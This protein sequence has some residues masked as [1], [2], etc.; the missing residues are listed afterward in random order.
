MNQRTLDMTRGKPISLIT[1]FAL[2]LMLGN[3]FQ[4]FY[5]VVDTA[6]VGKALGVGV[7]AAMGS[8]DWLGWMMVS[9]I[10]GLTQGFG[11]LMAQCFGARDEAGLRKTAGA[12][13]VLSALSAVVLLIAGQLAA[14]PVLRLLQTPE[15]IMHHGVQYLRYIFA[16]VPISMAYNLLACTLRSLGDGKTPLHA[17]MVA[18][19]VNVALDLL[20]VLAFR[21]GI[22]GAA[23][24]TLIAQACSVAF[25][26]V[27]IRRLPVL[28]LQKSDLHL[29]GRRAWRL[30]RLGFPVA[31]Q[32]AIISVGGMIVQTVVNGFGVAFIAGFTATNK[33]Y[34]VLEIAATSY[35]YAMTTYAGQNLGAGNIQRIRQGTRAASWVC[36]VI[37]G[38]IA[39]IM[40]AFGRTVVGMFI[41]GTPEETK[42]AI[43][44][45][46]KYLTIMAACLPSLYLLYVFRSTI[47]GVG[48][49]VLPMT[50]GIAEFVMRVC[51]ALV[52]PLLVGEIGL[53]YA[54]VLAWIGADFILIPSYFIVLKQRERRFAHDTRI[55]P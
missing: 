10:Q 54:E 47:Q 39:G 11:I 17:M 50:S 31:M 3:V 27:R 14:A 44:V 7:L 5:T 42:A 8:T 49:T 34:G 22:P 19:C 16:G 25:C 51:A 37:S 53:F 52:L 23:I 43:D 24:A 41:S 18:S 36:L 12:S 2:P 1:S 55:D 28:K 48:N 26:L 21:W 40:I 29:T 33:L 4:Q 20:F 46:Y 9:F 30:L 38:V 13:V 35:G 6:V 45:A 32:N 15:E